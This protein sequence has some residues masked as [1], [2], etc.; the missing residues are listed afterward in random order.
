[1]ITQ[2]PPGAADLLRG[3]PAFSGLSQNAREDLAGRC[4]LRTFRAGAPLLPGRGRW[5]GVGVMLSGEARLLDERDGSVE[6]DRLA[7]GGVFAGESLLSGLPYSYQAYATSDC[8]VLLL[9]KAAFDDWLS[10]QPAL[11]GELRQAAASHERRAFL[12]SSFLAQVLEKTAIDAAAAAASDV[13]LA[14]GEHLITEG[15][16]ARSVYVVRAGRLRLSRGAAETV[17]F[18]EAG[19]LVEETG[20]IPGFARQA[21]FIAETECRIHAIAADVFRRLVTSQKAGPRLDAMI[22]EHRGDKASAEG[23]GGAPEEAEAVLQWQL[24][25]YRAPAQRFR[26]LS[27]HPAVRQQSAMDCGAACLATLCRSYGK[28]VSLN[29]LR[30]LARVG[31]AGA[32]MLHLMLA[33][34]QLGFEALPILSTLDHLRNNHLPALVNW[35]GFHWIVVYAIDDRR[36]L[37]A[38]P[39][40]GL[41]KIP[42]ADFTKGWTRYT[43]FVRPTPRFADLDQSPPT[44]DQ[45][46]PYLAPYRRTIVEIAAASFIIQVL[47]LLMPM[48]SKFVI[49]EVIVPQRE[50]WL[51]A[52]LA[53]ILTA[54]LLQW[55]VAWARQRLLIFVSYRVNLRLLADFYRHV[56]RLPLPFFERRRVG[57][58]VSRLEEN[59]K[60]TTFFTTTGVEF[61]IDSATAVL[62]FG[63]MW[64]YNPRL[65]AVVAA[66][67]VLH[68][69]NVYLITP[70]LQHGF[71]EV[72]ERG[73]ELESHTIESLTGLRTI[74]TL[75]VERYIRATWENLF[76]RATNAYFRTLVY[77]I[78]SG[79]ASQI[80]NVAGTV[81]VLFYGATLVL[82]GQLT[83]GGLV[84]FTLLV[85]GVM[86]P[87]T[88]LVGSWD[89][90]QE[91]LNA[92]ERLNDVYETAPEAPDEPGDELTVLQSL[93]GYIRFEDVTFR[94]DPDGNNVLQN[95]DL[96][97]LAGQRVAFVGRSG[98]GKST[99]VKLLLGFYRPTTGR[100]LVDGYDLSRLWLPSLRRQVGVVPQSSFLFHGTIRDNIAQARPD[101][102]A[103]DVQWA[104]TMAHAHEFI[105]RLPDGYQTMLDEQGANLSGGQRQRI[106]IARAILQDPRMVML[107]EATSALDNESE[108]RFIQN[109]DAAFPGRTVLMIAHRLSTVRHADIIVVL[110]RGTIIEQGTHDELIAK[111]GLYYF[112]STQQLN[113]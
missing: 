50:R 54:V 32:S 24:P 82:Q 33:A 67:F 64:Y 61:F 84:A 23:E 93:N 43:L 77:G 89:Q 58:V 108:R 20:T 17:G 12:E 36:A 98:S 81:A 68:F 86:Q 53:G 105:A 71:R 21:S 66:F 102:S 70:G 42:I 40:R 91:T 76:A 27:R 69:V 72:F 4:E 73:A 107:D 8:A 60:I 5:A 48:F 44:L 3:V 15:Q 104:A 59:T 52:A 22:A 55:T 96:E 90:L 83:I 14:P 109:F 11:V 1:M 56:L 94:Y 51:S 39:A 80:V 38:D 13:T 18:V 75:G 19:D 35:K 2:T 41:V 74:R 34:R 63:L 16:P 103:A 112:I 95:V 100:I 101:A 31:S 79:L 111:Q 7:A 29:R 46:T 9:S 57:D 49:D 62:Y 97:I 37:V 47:A 113:L 85:Q 88:K 110:D 45:F 87:I 25:E 10:A 6:I 92:V 26:W 65:T 106:A 30:E 78:A 99:L 28:R